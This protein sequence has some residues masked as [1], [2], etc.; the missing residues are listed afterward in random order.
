MSPQMRSGFPKK[1][2][3]TALQIGPGVDE[4]GEQD[5]K[6]EQPH[7]CGDEHRPRERGTRSNVIPAGRSAMTVVAI[8]I[9]AASRATTISPSEV[10]VRSVES[11]RVK[12]VGPRPPSATNEAMCN[13]A[14]TSQAQNDA[15]A[16]RGNAIE[17]EPICNGTIAVAIP[18]SNGK[19]TRNTP[20]VRTRAQAC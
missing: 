7:R 1:I 19:P 3:V 13:P 6:R 10:K 14:P 9:L 15:A 12:A 8:Q 4:I 11:V 17:G 5:G 20:E 16:S 18:M 2:G